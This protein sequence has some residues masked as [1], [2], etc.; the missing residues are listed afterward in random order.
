MRRALLFEFTHYERKRGDIALRVALEN[1]DVLVAHEPG[2]GEGF[3]ET[4]SR[5]V[6]GGG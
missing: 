6:E 2:I 3:E 1:G 4:I 5:V